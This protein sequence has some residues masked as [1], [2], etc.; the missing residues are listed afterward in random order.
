[1]HKTQAVIKEIQNFSQ[2]KNESFA[3]CWTRFKDL[4]RRCPH[5]GFDKFRQVS[6]CYGGLNP[7]TK[8]L[9][10]TMC[11][12]SFLA[13]GAEKAEAHL[14]YVFETSRGWDRSSNIDQKLGSTPVSKP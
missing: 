14:E 3:Q 4:L 11:T 8:K 10:E 9:I 6:I 12:G 1:M 13:L 2:G 7:D 5:H